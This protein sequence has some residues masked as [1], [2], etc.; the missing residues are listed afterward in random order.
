MEQAGAT[1]QEVTWDDGPYYDLSVNLGKSQRY[2]SAMCEFYTRGHDIAQAL[3][4]ISGSSAFVALLPDNPNTLVPKI[5]TAV[6]ALSTTLDLVFNPAKKADIHA[7][8]HKRF[9][10]L[11]GEQRAATPNAESFQRI[12]SKRLEIEA[13][14][15]PVRRL[16][17]IK[18]QNDECRSRGVPIEGL[19]PLGFWQESWFGYLF[20]FGTRGLEKRIRNRAKAANRS[21]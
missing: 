5:L 13:D 6:V 11:A 1:A 19:V 18:A 7:A 10:H 8:L 14:E 17:D 3:T 12:Y 20:T 4:A 15:P 9:T 2:H 16:I 21:T